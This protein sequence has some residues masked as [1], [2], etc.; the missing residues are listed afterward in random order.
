MT[1]LAPTPRL[2]TDR[3]LMREWLDSDRAPYAALNGDA[4]V[5]RHFPSMLTPQQSDEMIE[6]MVA[7]WRDRGHGLWAVERQ[8]TME[9]IGFVGLAAPAWQAS[10]TP[11]VEVGWRLAKQY[12]GHGFAP[13]AAHAA[14]AWGFENV[15]LPGDEI[16][17]FTTQANLN[18]RRV[19]EKIGMTYDPDDDFDHPLLPDWVDRRHVRYRINRRQF[20]ESMAR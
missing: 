14:L 15:D 8:D 20:A 6:R 11:C 16:L 7:S 18:S 5:M 10:F 1:T 2:I 3:L 13:E 12:W 9:F 19:M 17:S 4:E